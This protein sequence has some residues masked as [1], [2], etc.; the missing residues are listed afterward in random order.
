MAVL[1]TNSLKDW[2]SNFFCF[3][4]NQ[5]PFFNIS[6]TQQ[7]KLIIYCGS[8]GHPSVPHH[9]SIPQTGHSRP[10]SNLI[11]PILLELIVIV[12]MFYFSRKILFAFN[13][14][15]NKSAIKE[16]LFFFYFS[17]NFRDLFVNWSKYCF[18]YHAS[19]LKFKYAK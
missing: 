4:R 7:L 14:S 8:N 3:L 17:L 12:F 18:S 13:S 6:I 19:N 16:S 2:V 15:C 5:H 1:L 11:F 10:S 9:S